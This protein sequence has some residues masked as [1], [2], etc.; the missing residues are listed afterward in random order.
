MGILVLL[1]GADLGF[2]DAVRLPLSFLL[3]LFLWLL[4][5]RRTEIF[6]DIEKKLKH[7]KT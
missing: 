3:V 6:K 5:G 4:L 7:E 2:S 1:F